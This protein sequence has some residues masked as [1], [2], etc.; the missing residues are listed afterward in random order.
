MKSEERNNVQQRIGYTFENPDLLQQAFVRKSY[1]EEH[2]GENNEVLEFIGDKALD[3]AVVKFL[4]ECYGSMQLKHEDYELSRTS[5][6]YVSKHNESTLTL[7]KSDLVQKETL[8]ARI[9][10]LGLTE[11]LLMGNGDM[12]TDAAS[13][14]SVKEDLFEA[15]VGAVALD[16]K[17]NLEKIQ[18]VVA[19]MLSLD[20]MI[21][22]DGDRLFFQKWTLK[23]Y[24]VVPTYFYLE[25]EEEWVSPEEKKVITLISEGAYQ[26]FLQLGDFDVIFRAFGDSKKKARKKVNE[27]ASVYLDENNL[28]LTS[29]DEVGEPTLE[30]AINQL[31]EL[32]QKGYI[33]RLGYSFETFVDNEDNSIWEC[34][35]FC[36]YGPLDF[37]FKQAAQAKKD[38]KK[39]AALEMMRHIANLRLPD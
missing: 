13:Q 27:V 6:V 4:S 3:L 25:G 2:G 5:N 10:Y 32:S 20:D 8:A 18:D 1:S 12:K 28:F 24:G 11:Y 36:E 37:E 33:E 35:C 22:C 16:S 26:C 14:A 15:I 19:T 23:K 29:K 30:R 39:Y 17:W 21:L 31:Q 38:A 7:I 9:D 34:T